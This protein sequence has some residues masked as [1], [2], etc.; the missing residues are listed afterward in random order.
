MHSSE[1][2]VKQHPDYV[3]AKSGNIVAAERLVADL[4]DVDAIQ[5]LRKLTTA[6]YVKIVPVHALET[7][8]VNQ[9]PA[10]LAT[11]LAEALGFELWAGVVQVNT[12]GHTGADGFH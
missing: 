5:R 9:I 10:A 1:T 12:V 6:D 4:V 7:D 11:S 8:V 2:M 3:A